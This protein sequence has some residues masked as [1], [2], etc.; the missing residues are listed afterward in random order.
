MRSTADCFPELRSHLHDGIATDSRIGI[1]HWE[2]ANEHVGMTDERE[3]IPLKLPRDWADFA[4]IDE[5]LRR[6]G[7][8]AMLSNR[9]V[10]SGHPTIMVLSDYSGDAR[11]C[12]Y[13]T[14]SFLFV[15]WKSLQQWH[16][17]TS[18]LR[19]TAL[20][21]RIPE[22][23][24]LGDHNRQQAL[25][26]WLSLADGIHGFLVTIAVHKQVRIF[27]V[28]GTG[29]GE[30]LESEGFGGWP[31]KT[32]ERMARILHFLWFFARHMVAESSKLFWKSDED[33]I[34][35]SG[36]NSPRLQQLGSLL[37]RIGN[38]YL[39]H[40]VAEIGYAV[41]RSVDSPDRMLENAL[42]IPDLAAGVLADF[43]SL[44]RSENVRKHGREE[45]LHWFAVR[46]SSLV[47]FIIRVDPAGIGSDNRHM[48]QA[49][50]VEI[51]SDE[52]GMKSA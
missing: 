36:G 39:P 9:E 42:S 51:G 40:A 34:A 25:K 32:A 3:G 8:N 30:A 26:R 20:E 46:G 43:F 1:K 13:R 15:G 29:L 33:S 16:I 22:Y 5:M 17:S 28:E 45:I 50:L 52:T 31:D 21:N 6:N 10:F 23:K 37:V 49:K 35:G 41:G 19:T 2:D 7:I 4:A 18:E 47:R 38:L 27:R 14:Y 11:G 48:Y 44:Q 12:E 24:K